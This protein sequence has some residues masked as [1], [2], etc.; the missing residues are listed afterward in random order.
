MGSGRGGAEAAQNAAHDKAD[1]AK[2]NFDLATGFKKDLSAATEDVTIESMLSMENAIK[3][4]DRNLSRQE[5]L[6]KQID[7]AIL[8]ASQSALRIMRGDQNNPFSRQRALGRQ[9]LLNRLREQL[10]PGAETSSIGLKAL[11]QFDSETDAGTTGAAQGYGQIAQQFSGLRPNMLQE[12]TGLSNLAAGRAGLRYQQQGLIQG[13]NNNILQMGQGL[14]DT[15]GWQHTAAIINSQN[16][17]AFQNQL[18]GGAFT[19]GGAMLGGAPAGKLPQMVAG[20]N[21]SAGGSLLD[22]TGLA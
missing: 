5:E 7:P 20:S 17:Q 14:T 9:K 13:A 21:N 10:G 11:S 8:E 22:V 3:A 12:S 2:K 6:V 18:I 15:A 16:R 1:Q 4:Q 19:L